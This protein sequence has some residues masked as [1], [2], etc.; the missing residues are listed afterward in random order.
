M[1]SSGTAR[2]RVQRRL[3]GKD[4]SG[5]SATI[6]VETVSCMIARI[7]KRSKKTFV[8]R[9]TECPAPFAHL[10]TMMGPLDH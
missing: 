8:P 3:R 6:V 7:G 2:H 10:V 4:K 1:I 9:K 5:Y